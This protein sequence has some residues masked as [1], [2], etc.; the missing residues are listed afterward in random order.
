MVNRLT[1]CAGTDAV[2]AHAALPQ[3]HTGSGVGENN[4]GADA[5]IPYEVDEEVADDANADKADEE[6][7]SSCTV[8]DDDER[9]AASGD[10]ATNDDGA[11]DSA[12]LA[13]D[14]DDNG[15]DDDDDDDA[16]DDGDCP[17]VEGE[18]DGD[19]TDEK[20]MG[21]RIVQFSAGAMARR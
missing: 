11:D 4:D 8:D 18:G 12:D 17:K 6:D 14:K 20:P 7:W 13:D 10:D 5:A 16:D 9:A 2:P 3:L 15:E 19:E 1:L 21:T